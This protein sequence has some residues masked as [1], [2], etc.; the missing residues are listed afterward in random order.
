MGEGN[1]SSKEARVKVI[2]VIQV[3]ARRYARPDLAAQ[4][5]ATFATDRLFRKHREQWALKHN[6]D[7]YGLWGVLQER[8]TR[9]ILPIFQKALS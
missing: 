4:E 2:T 8:M 5:Y 9:R 3:G 1:M 6:G 7:R